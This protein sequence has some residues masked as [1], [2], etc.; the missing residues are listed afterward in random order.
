MDAVLPFLA[1]L[2]GAFLFG[3]A[4]A[5]GSYAMSR[6]LRPAKI[7]YSIDAEGADEDTIDRLEHTLRSHARQISQCSPNTLLR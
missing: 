2:V 4:A 6:W 3:A 7:T 5:L 1:L